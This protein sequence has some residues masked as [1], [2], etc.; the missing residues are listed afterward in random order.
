MKLWASL[1]ATAVFASSI[2]SAEAAPTPEAVA[3]I[4]TEFNENLSEDTDG[5][6]YVTGAFESDLW[7]ISPGGKVEKLAHFN[8]YPIILGI[9][10]RPDGL[11]MGIMRRDFRKPGGIDISDVG[12]EI[13][14]LDKKGKVL[15]TVPGQKG[16]VFNGM[17]AD[18]HGRV[19]LTDSGGGAI[20]QFDPKTRKI[21]TW[22]KDP[23]LA[24]VKGLGANG[25]KVTRD[26]VY[27]GNREKASIY[28]VRRDAEGRPQGSPVLVAD[29]LTD[30]DD[31]A[32]APN[33]VIYV[34]PRDPAK[35]GPMLRITPDGKSSTFLTGQY[36]PSAVVSRDGKWVYWASGAGPAK[37]WRA[38]IS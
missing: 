31:F 11:I 4:P 18:G 22:L 13:V 6:F 30:V 32:V 16:Q 2:G 28:R 20:L 27:V 25:L 17:V 23:V 1:L 9:V 10:A 34:P 33:D 37:L 3:S 12:P 36:G 26:W 29:G 15:A 7:K 8:E 19:L 35:P 38:P 21:S 5:T 24:P 14:M